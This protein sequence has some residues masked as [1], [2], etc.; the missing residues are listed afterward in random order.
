MVHDHR[1]TRPRTRRIQSDD[2][3][4]LTATRAWGEEASFE[5]GTYIRRTVHRPRYGR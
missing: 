5:V 2:N 4:A 1:P 3:F